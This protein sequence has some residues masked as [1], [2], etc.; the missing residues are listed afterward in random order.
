MWTQRKTAV[1]ESGS[2]LSSDTKPTIALILDSS[3]SR[4]V[5]NEF[6][7]LI[8]HPV[9]STLI[10]K[11]KLTKTLP[12]LLPG[13]QRRCYLESSLAFFSK[14]TS[15]HLCIYCMQFNHKANSLHI[16][17]ALPR[18]YNEDSAAVFLPARRNFLTW[19]M[20]VYCRES[21]V[22]VIEIRFSSWNS[23]M[24]RHILLQLKHIDYIEVWRKRKILFCLSKWNHC[25]E[26]LL[27]IN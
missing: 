2:R 17:S 9:Y 8:S 6:L 1:Y 14:I 5:R 24:S 27:I 7:L 12:T 3:T 22:L 4:T 15:A 26:E 13:I 11:F 21:N 16:K 10:Q 18:M 23:Q 20:W 19:G 25:T